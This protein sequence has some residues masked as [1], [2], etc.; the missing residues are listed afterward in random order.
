MKL[1]E[2]EPLFSFSF[3]FS[4]FRSWVYSKYGDGDNV[5]TITYGI[6]QALVAEIWVMASETESTLTNHVHGRDHSF[7]STCSPYLKKLNKTYEFTL[8]SLRLSAHPP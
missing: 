8:L 5:L 7:F 1:K 4:S 3:F 6:S 2:M